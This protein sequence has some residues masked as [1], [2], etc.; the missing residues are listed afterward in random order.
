MQR[1]AATLSPEE[2]ARASRFAFARDRD[3]FVAARGILREL[4]GTYLEKSASEISLCYGS[5]GKPALSANG[6]KP[7]IHFNLS[8]S[9]GLAVFAFS[10]DRELGVDVERVRQDYAREDVAA[11]NFTAREIA[12]LRGLAPESR[13]EWFFRCWTRKEAC[14]KAWSAGL[15]IPLASFDVPLKVGV[16]STVTDSKGGC[17]TLQGF[18]ARPGYTGAVVGQGGGWKLR[19]WDWSLAPR[20]HK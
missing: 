2:N 5:A 7:Q 3:Y 13:A 8:H 18:E 14:V 1:L 19:Y 12:K 20:A 17:W 10:A 15:Q 16:E 9:D 11:G 4:L 6:A